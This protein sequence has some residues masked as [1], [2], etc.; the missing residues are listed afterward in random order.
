MAYKL[1]HLTSKPQF[2]SELAQIGNGV[3]PLSPKSKVPMA[4]SGGF[5]DA[6]QTS[7]EAATLF[8]RTKANVGFATGNGILVV[9]IDGSE[10]EEGLEAVETAGG[11]VLPETFTVITPTGGI[12]LYYTYDA[13]AHEITSRQN[14]PCPK[15]DI[16]AD[17]GYV[18]APP[19]YAEYVKDDVAISGDYHI[20]VEAG[21][22]IRP[23]PDWFI[24]L[25]KTNRPSKKGTSRREDIRRFDASMLDYIQSDDRDLWV[26]VGMGLHTTYG[27][28]A[29][30]FWQAWSG[31]SD[32]YEGLEDC[33]RVWASFGKSDGPKV[34]VASV[35][36]LAREKGWEPGS[37]LDASIKRL[38][39]L[40]SKPKPE[41]RI[42]Y[43]ELL[44][45]VSSLMTHL[46]R[47]VY[48]DVRGKSQVVATAR[49]VSCALAALGLT[50]RMNVITR[51]PELFSDDEYIE[52]LI[53]DGKDR[54]AITDV[55][56]GRCVSSGMPTVNAITATLY[57]LGQTYP[58]NPFETWALADPWD[59][60]DRV[61]ALMDTI[62]L[63][64]RDPGGDEMLEAYLRHWLRAGAVAAT[65]YT[66]PRQIRGVLTFVGP[67]RAGKTM[68][69]K[70]LVPDGWYAEGVQMDFNRAG[71]DSIMQATA[72]PLVELGELDAT[73]RKSD[74]AAL[75]GFLSQSM[76]RYRPPYGRAL[77]E[78][79]RISLY[80]ASVNHDKFLRD[81]TGASRF[82]PVQVLKCK[83]QHNID[84]QQLWAQAFAELAKGEPWH[85]GDD[86]AAINE[87]NAEEF[88]DAPMSWGVLE[89]KCLG[90]QE[91]GMYGWFTVSALCEA[92]GLSLNNS[93]KGDV[94]A[95]LDKRHLGY[96]KE[97]SMAGIRRRNVY[98]VPMPRNA[99][100][101][102]MSVEDWKKAPTRDDP[103]R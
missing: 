29:F 47:R 25:I 87:A 99:R 44:E 50:V 70:S 68:W 41:T 69:F 84:I 52:N 23:C 74:Q 76:D 16:R 89:D 33:Q 83:W 12:H 88:Q 103:K 20:D 80:C 79:P 82:W 72:A 5:K 54:R 57:E 26:R 77:I 75:K 93:N 81:P 63:D 95:W 90:D 65:N 48:V 97:L 53:V 32:K 22:Y 56:L 43:G 102:A 66:K 39:Q 30:G 27:D 7:E 64:P 21:P 40:K 11:E 60:I 13:E 1:P 37:S 24:E 31:R 55:F 17:G 28:D 8:K 78:F 92:V 34:S 42:P 101:F 46:V 62:M 100:R 4:K 38:E 6:V 67:Q 10:G 49:N 86:L 96:K 73:F 61:P 51:E 58:Y 3:F 19:S 45:N 98:R 14:N 85:L 35:I 9:D 15:V 59:G 94:A 2:A 91:K 71:K 36:Q 18:V